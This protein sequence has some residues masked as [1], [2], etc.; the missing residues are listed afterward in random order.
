MEHPDNVVIEERFNIDKSLLIPF[1]TPLQLEIDGVLARL[2]SWSVGLLL[3][4]CL[5]I[6]YPKTAGLGPIA[7]KLFKG[8]KIIVRYIDR[9][10]VFAFESKV[11]GFI[12]EPAKLIFVAYPS[13]ISRHNLRK[14]TRVVCSLLAEVEAMGEKY[15]GLITDLSETGCCLNITAQPTG[16]SFPSMRIDQAFLIRCQLPGIGAPIEI[17]GLA[18]HLQ[19]DGQKSIIGTLFH[20]VDPLVRDDICNFVMTVQKIL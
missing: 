10:N 9:G 13:A 8:N 17:V 2:K 18:K 20:D 5:I 19:R 3:E 15:D 1:G 7:H 4:E 12:T 14:A 6:K 16:K 11:L